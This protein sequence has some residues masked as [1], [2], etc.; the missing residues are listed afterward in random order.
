MENKKLQEL[1]SSFPTVFGSEILNTS[2]FTVNDV[3]QISEIGYSAVINSQ[4]ITF[5]KQDSASL[6]DMVMKY[7]E[8]DYH[9]LGS[10]KSRLYDKSHSITLSD[11]VWAAINRLPNEEK[12]YEAIVRN[13]NTMVL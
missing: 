3:S 10:L 6:H 11:L 4:Y 7:I 13:I 2:D 5:H 8:L 1:L 12:T 9:T